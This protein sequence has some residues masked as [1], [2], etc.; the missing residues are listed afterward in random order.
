[1]R[2]IDPASSSGSAHLYSVRLAQLSTRP[3]EKRGYS[4]NPVA[5]AKFFAI[6]H[7]RPKVSRADFCRGLYSIIQKTV[8]M[9]GKKKKKFLHPTSVADRSVETYIY[10]SSF[11]PNVFRPVDRV[12]RGC[13]QVGLVDFP[14]FSPIGFLSHFLPI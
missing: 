4:G 10:P 5:V 3:A 11:L 12:E 14:F 13:R 8:E 6:S 7:S 2:A 9:D 1:M